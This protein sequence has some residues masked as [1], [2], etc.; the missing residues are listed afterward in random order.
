MWA[1]I[2]SLCKDGCRLKRTMSP[3]IK[4]LSTTSPNLSSCAIFSRFPY[5]KNLT[6]RRGFS[7]VMNHISVKTWFKFFPRSSQT[8]LFICV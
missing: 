7:L 2:L 1:M 8:H 5:F 6:D 3:S 4:C